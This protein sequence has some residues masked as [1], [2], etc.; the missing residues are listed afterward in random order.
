M[1]IVSYRFLPT[2]GIPIDVF[3][4]FIVRDNPLVV[5]DLV[6]VRLLQLLSFLL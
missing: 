4:E 5:L 2:R 6:A 1:C 3:L